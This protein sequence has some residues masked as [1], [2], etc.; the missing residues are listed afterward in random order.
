MLP[1]GSVYVLSATIVHASKQRAGRAGR[2]YSVNTTIEGSVYAV[3]EEKTKQSS[4]NAVQVKGISVCG[5]PLSS[6][7][8]Y[9]Y[10]LAFL[11]KHTLVSSHHSYK[12]KG[13]DFVA[14][15]SRKTRDGGIDWFVDTKFFHGGPVPKLYAESMMGKY[16][17]VA[18]F[19]F[20]KR[21]T[22]KKTFLRWLEQ[23]QQANR[24]PSHISTDPIITTAINDEQKA[25]DVAATTQ[26]AYTPQSPVYE[27]SRGHIDTTVEES[28]GNNLLTTSELSEKKL[29]DSLS[30]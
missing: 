4:P 22:N 17:N 8:H 29:P 6:D 3:G 27:R 23:E 28:D 16:D 7:Y 11:G 18:L 10:K 20:E 15:F 24:L 2:Y 21:T 13:M 14:L 25:S 9:T 1:I 12:T 30:P 26:A 5:L 19:F